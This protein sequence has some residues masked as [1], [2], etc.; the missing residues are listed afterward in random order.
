MFALDSPPLGQTLFY[1]FISRVYFNTHF[2]IFFLYVF[3]SD[4]LNV[5]S[6]LYM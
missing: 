1:N 4:S 3:I 2:N 6:I 5:F